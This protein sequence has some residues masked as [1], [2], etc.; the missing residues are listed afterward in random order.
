MMVVWVSAIIARQET[1]SDHIVQLLNSSEL[2]K[3]LWMVPLAVFINGL[4]LALNY[5]NSRT[6]H[7]GRLSI[8]RV[9]S[10]V[11]AQGAKL[12]ADFAGFVSSGVFIGTQSL[13][14]NHTY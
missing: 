8:A 7:Y 13:K 5:W 11:T 14:I 2:R 4:F 6:K 3:Y 12:S 1:I 9:V 10:S